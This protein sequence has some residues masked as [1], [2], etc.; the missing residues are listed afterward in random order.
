MKPLQ[1]FGSLLGPTWPFENALCSAKS[2]AKLFQF[3]PKPTLKEWLQAGGG[4]TG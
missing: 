4:V 3:A 2:T 1:A